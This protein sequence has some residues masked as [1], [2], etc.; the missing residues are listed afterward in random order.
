MTY[1]E[2][3]ADI[4]HELDVELRAIEDGLLSQGGRLAALTERV[5][6]L[7]QQ[8]PVPDPDPC[9]DPDPDPD[10]RVPMTLRADPNFDAG[11]LSAAQQARLATMKRLIDD[12]EGGNRDPYVIANR[13]CIWWYSHDLR[14]HI[15]A[16]V[17]AFRVTGDLYFL[18]VI[19][20]LGELM[21]S[22]LDYPY[23]ST[24]PDGA[25][26]GEN[27]GY[28]KWVERQNPTPD[29]QGTDTRI[30]YDYN[31]HTTSA[32]MTWILHHNRDLDSPKGYDYGEHA[33]FMLSYHVNHFEA[34]HRARRRKPTGFPIHNWPPQ[35]DRHIG[36]AAWHYYMGLLTGDAA[37]TNEAKRMIDVEHEAG[38]LC[39][40]S[41]SVGDAYV[42]RRNIQSISTF[43]NRLSETG[44]VEF[45]SQAVLDLHFEGFHTWADPVHLKRFAT[46][47]T[48]YILD[49]P[50]PIR[51]GLGVDVGGGVN[52]CGWTSSGII[53]L[54]AFRQQNSALALLAPWDL[55]GTRIFDWSEDCIAYAIPRSY[56]YVRV[57]AAQMLYAHLRGE[58]A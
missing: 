35:Y 45:V 22:N 33:D 36:W 11:T 53:R 30:D 6:A 10:V 17:A 9:P 18:D 23:R 4:G 5:L 41:T 52:R 38:N 24:H 55:T 2:R 58:P 34:K 21:R 42:W 48:E 32:W 57:L 19:Y 1:E 37:Y 12:K 43:G 27:D 50:D 31:A 54:N 16:Q 51:N 7:E 25:T 13:D 28:L 14:T 20:E 49:D 56:D 3:L 15:A 39:R 26:E 40:S 8:E 47:L 44:Y 46:T 29:R